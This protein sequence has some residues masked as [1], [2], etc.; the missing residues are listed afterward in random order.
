VEPFG[1]FRLDGEE[2]RCVGGRTGV[3]DRFL[4]TV[5]QSATADWSTTFKATP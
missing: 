5:Q 2:R 1:Q 3:P 4:K